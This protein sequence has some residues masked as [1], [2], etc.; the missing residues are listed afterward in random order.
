MILIT[1]APGN[2]ANAVIRE[3]TKAGVRV[4]ALLRNPN[5]AGEIKG[6]LVEVAVGDFLNPA[7]LHAA[8]QGVEKAFLIPPMDP[9]SVEMQASFIRAA[10]RAGTGHVVKLSV[11]GADVNSPVRVA[12]WHA[13]GEKELEA[14]GIPF[15][16]L[17]PN[18]FMQNFLGL[19]PTIVS[20]GEF[21]QP[22]ADGK[23]SHIDVRD[24]A[25]V[26]AK[27]L[28]ENGHQ[29]KT[30]VITGPEALSYDDVA[31]KLSTALGRPV[32]YVNITPEDFKKSLLGWGIPEFMADGL[33]EFFAAIRAGYCAVVTNTVEEVAQRK[34]IRFDNFVRDFADAFTARPQAAG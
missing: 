9:R 25:A 4:R 7:S 15:T 3:L 12:R 8:L 29:G 1:S 28:T 11:N 22:A 26:A 32:K 31:R 13:E 34:P 33:N 21:Y 20:Q 27:A 19:A 30:Y 17:R 5:S 18:A 6:P 2:N 23:V 16:H 14:S 10:K 24:I